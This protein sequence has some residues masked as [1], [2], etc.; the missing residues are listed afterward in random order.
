MAP[1]M[2][3]TLALAASLQA[4]PAATHFAGTWA[5]PVLNCYAGQGC[6]GG[7]SWFAVDKTGRYHGWTLAKKPGDGCLSFDA[8]GWTGQLYR[9]NRGTLYAINDGAE[10]G[11]ILQVSRDRQSAASTYIGAAAGV[12]ETNQLFRSAPIDADLLLAL[13]EAAACE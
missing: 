13:A 9:L 10:D 2:I 8:D 7:Y 12:V 4:L 3:A 1:A 5:G 11:Y 6:M